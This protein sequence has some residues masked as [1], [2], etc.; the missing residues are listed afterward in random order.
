MTTGKIERW[1][2]TLRREV[3]ASAVVIARSFG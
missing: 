3:L 1:H 2:Q